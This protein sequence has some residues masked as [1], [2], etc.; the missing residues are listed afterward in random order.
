MTTPIDR[1]AE[2][3]W[4][5]VMPRFMPH[6]PTQPVESGPAWDAVMPRFM[7]TE[8][9]WATTP[10]KHRAGMPTAVVRLDD[11]HKS[12]KAKEPS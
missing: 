2:G 3:T 10:G 1:P 11:L 4:A 7:G 12:G 9:A 5:S 6:H 8:K